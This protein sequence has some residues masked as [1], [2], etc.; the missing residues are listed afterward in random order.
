MSAKTLILVASALGATLALSLAAH[1]NLGVLD[2]TVEEQTPSEAISG[3]IDG[4][5]SAEFAGAAEA[6]SL[7]LTASAVRV[8]TF[9]P[10]ILDAYPSSVQTESTV[11]FAWDLDGDGAYDEETSEARLVY[12]Y[13]DDGLYD[14][15]VRATVADGS[16]TVSDPVTLEISNRAPM[17][18]FSSSPIA[19]SDAAPIAFAD[20]SSDRDG[21]IVSW[22]WDFGDGSTA[23]SPDPMHAFSAPGTYAVSLVVIDDDG[24]PSIPFRRSIEI[25]NALPTASFEISVGASAGEDVTFTDRSIDP[26]SGGRVVHV[27]WDF[28]DGTY[29]AGGPS[30]SGTYKHV[31]ASPGSYTVTLFVID[32]N[33]G[34]DTAKQTITVLGSA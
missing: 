17:A 6:P 2:T 22:R 23:S 16:E 9:V 11:T 3:D 1:A 7:L 33:G 12:T 29:V 19:G 15:Q 31:Y 30:P 21:A 20:S 26:S 24:T 5:S 18:R 13:E 14:V 4:S 32:A 10:V 34:L 8:E 28:G 27:A 25:T